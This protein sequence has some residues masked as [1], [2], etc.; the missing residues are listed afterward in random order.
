MVRKVAFVVFLALQFSVLASLASAGI[1]IPYC[2]T[3][4]LR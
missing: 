3:C 1:P 2:P 4:Y